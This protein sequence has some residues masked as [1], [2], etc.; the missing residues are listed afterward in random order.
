MAGF[1]LQRSACLCS[2][3]A[4]IKG[5]CHHGRLKSVTRAS[6]LAVGKQRQEDQKVSMAFDFTLPELHGILS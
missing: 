1:E 2:P 3:S 4:G 6:S 5:V